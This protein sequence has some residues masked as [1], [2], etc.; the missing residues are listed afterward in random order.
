[1][2]SQLVFKV[3]DFFLLKMVLIRG[4]RK[5]AYLERGVGGAKRRISA[6]DWMKRRRR[7][8]RGRFA[9]AVRRVV[10]HNAE[11]KR[12]FRVMNKNEMYHNGGAPGG[13]GPGTVVFYQLNDSSGIPVQGTTDAT[14]VGD[15]IYIRGFSLKLM[16]GQK[17]DRMNVTWR[18][19]VVS[20][21]V[22]NYD[23]QF[24]SVFV[25]ATN[26]VLLDTVNT[27]RF[28][29]VASKTIHKMIDPQL[30]TSGDRREL[31]FPVKIWIPDGKTYR[32]RSANATAHNQNGLYLVVMCYDAFGTLQTDNIGYFQG[33]CVTYFKDP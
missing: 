14:R 9:R 5:A 33:A 30:S 10:L 21:P 6:P 16:L 8:A 19:M 18:I 26:N 4:K 20:A 1:L 2:G 27:E 22:A 7:Y 11:Q 31:T 29:V 3:D 23:N 32:F 13:G 25:A 15:S 24:S 28:R 12:L 17:S